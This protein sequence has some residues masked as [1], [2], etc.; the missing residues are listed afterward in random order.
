MHLSTLIRSRGLALS[1]CSLIFDEGEKV[2]KT[3][4]LSDHFLVKTVALMRSSSPHLLA[5]HN[6]DFPSIPFMVIKFEQID[7]SPNKLKIPLILRLVPIMVCTIFSFA[8]ILPSSVCV[9]YT[10]RTNRLFFMHSLSTIV[11]VLDFGAIMIIRSII[12]F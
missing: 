5:H 3:L 1:V 12:G 4:V 10:Q 11:V 2:V 7:V 9:Q 8:R 6:I